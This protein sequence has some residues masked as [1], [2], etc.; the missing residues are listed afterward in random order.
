MHLLDD[1]CIY[2]DLGSNLQPWRIG[3][4]FYPT[5]RPGSKNIFIYMFLILKS[6]VLKL[7]YGGYYNYLDLETDFYFLQ[8]V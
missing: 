8:V 6:P 5:E 2:H 4:M 7:V 3:M 1:S